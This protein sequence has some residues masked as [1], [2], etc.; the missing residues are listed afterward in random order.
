MRAL[1]LI[2]V[3]LFS[4]SSQASPAPTAQSLLEKHSLALGPLA[5]I[6]TRRVQMHIIGMAPFDI[7][8]TIEASRPNLIRKDVTLQ[9]AVQ[10]TAF[11][12]KLA[13]K[14]DPF[15]P[16]GAAPSSLPAD[17]AKALLGEA[18]FDGMLIQ[19]ASKGIKVAY[20]GPATVDGKAAHTLRITQANGDTATVWLDAATYLE[21]KRT[22]AG[23]VAGAMKDLD[24]FTSDY[25]V[26]DGIKVPHKIEIGL[27]GAKEKMSILVDKVELNPRIDASRFAKP[28][29]K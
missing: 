3:S 26:V 18:D 16:G 25:R 9:G 22:Q 4:L 17:E 27:S 1:L 15:V 11:D 14:T 5:Q 2:L 6:Q 20:L 13:W 29:A 10:V 24:I 12:G 8:V 7:P 21:F 19:P 23:P 28:A